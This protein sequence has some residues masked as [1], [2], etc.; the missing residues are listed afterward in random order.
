VERGWFRMI[1]T[2]GKSLFVRERWGLPFVLVGFTVAAY[3][4]CSGR[5]LLPY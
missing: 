3:M 4:T 2:K 1:E 5:A